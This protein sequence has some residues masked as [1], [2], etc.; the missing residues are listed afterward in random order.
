MWITKKKY[1]KI[2]NLIEGLGKEV[3]SAVE[4]FTEAMER[5]NEETKLL[6]E[7]LTKKNDFIEN[8]LSQMIS[9]AVSSISVP[10]AASTSASVPIT[11]NGSG[12]KSEVME[13]YL[14]KKN[15][16]TM[17]KLPG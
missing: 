13:R 12:A 9:G 1:Y 11:T 8:L 17:R 6:R 16:E 15:A 7:E 10:R 5:M 2:L 4:D 3:G 14:A